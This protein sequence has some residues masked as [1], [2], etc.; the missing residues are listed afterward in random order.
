MRR[1]LL[2]FT[3]FLFLTLFPS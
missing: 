2:L 1:H 3:L